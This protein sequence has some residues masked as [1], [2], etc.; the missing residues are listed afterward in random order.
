MRKPSTRAEPPSPIVSQPSK[1]VTLPPQY[2]TAIVDASNVKISFA[3]ILHVELLK[4]FTLV[5]HVYYVANL[6]QFAPII[7][8]CQTI[9]AYA[10]QGLWSERNSPSAEYKSA[11]C[12][13]SSNMNVHKVFRVRMC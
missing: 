10:P 5:V 8:K 6:S 1:V 4:Q 9:H 7:T 3:V 11:A 13:I 2:S 12:Y